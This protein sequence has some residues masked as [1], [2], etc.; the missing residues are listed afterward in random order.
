M[1]WAGF[2]LRF[3]VR[4]LLH[5][6]HP[7]S[8]LSHLY[9]LRGAFF[10]YDYPE[11]KLLAFQSHMNRYENFIWPLGMMLP[12]LDGKKLLRNILG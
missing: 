6:W 1:N 10:R 12:F 5:G 11:D 4:M 2:D 9:L 8:P 3:A 7:D